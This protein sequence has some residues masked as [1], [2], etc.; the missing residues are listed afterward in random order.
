LDS[1][2]LRG[3]FGPEREGLRRGQKKPQDVGPK[4]LKLCTGSCKN[5]LKMWAF[6]SVM[7]N[8][9]VGCEK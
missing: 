3:E 4:L 6:V 8:V 7:F 5:D 1:G 2:A 9:H